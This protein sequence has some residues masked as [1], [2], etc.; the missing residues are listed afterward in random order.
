VKLE[1]RRDG[2]IQILSVSGPVA[3]KEIGVLKAGIMKYFRDG[4]NKIILEMRSASDL[5]PENLREFALL[6]LIA[7]ELSGSVVLAGVDSDT[8]LRIKTFSSPPMIQAFA[9]AELATQ[10]FKAPKKK[11]ALATTKPK[12]PQPEA[13]KPPAPEPALTPEESSRIRAQFRQKETQDIMVLRKEI[14]SLK[15]QNLTLIEQVEALMKDRRIPPND[16]SALERI[17]TFKA[18]GVQLANQVT[19]LTQKA[20]A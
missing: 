20:K 16:A 18:L 17:E 13:A 1:L 6:H 7:T 4:K 3:E 12:Q 8:A 11:P 14:E 19:Q 5:T 2:D 9:T 10:Y 15:A